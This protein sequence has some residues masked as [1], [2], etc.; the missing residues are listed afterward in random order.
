MEIFVTTSVY[1]NQ[2]F[3]KYVLHKGLASELEYKPG[4]FQ[5]FSERVFKWKLDEFTQIFRSQLNLDVETNNHLLNAKNALPTMNLALFE[6]T[7]I[8][9]ILE[10]SPKIRFYRNQLEN[11]QKDKIAKEFLIDSDKVI[12]SPETFNGKTTIDTLKQ[13]KIREI[14]YETKN[15]IEFFYIAKKNAK[16]NFFGNFPRN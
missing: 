10:A 9:S 3:Q 1:K 2:P 13:L 6:H 15:L 4:V 11:F 8:M 7:D 14:T 12:A 5:G 16:A